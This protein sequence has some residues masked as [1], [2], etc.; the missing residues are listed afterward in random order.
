MKKAIISSGIFLSASLLLGS[1]SKFE[2]INTN[3][4]DATADQVQVEYF[5]NNSI[6]KAQMDPHIAERVF[7]LYWK[8]AAHQHV[9]TG[10]AG[11]TTDDGW[12]TDYFRYMSEWLN[13]ANSAIS[14]ADEHLAAAAPIRKE[15]TANLKE[16]ARIWRAYLMSEWT[17]N[18]GPVPINAFQG[19]NPEYVDVKQVYYFLLA[20]LKDA[21]AKLD[22]NVT[23][24]P[25]TVSNLDPAYGYNAAKWR[26]YANSMRMRLAM[27][28]SEVD[29]EKARAEFEDAV[30]GEMISSTDY[31]FQVQEKDGWSPLSGVMSREWNPQL[32]P[33]SLENIYVG[34]GGVPSADLVSADV[35]SHIKPAN[36]AGLRIT[37]HLSTITNEPYAG[38]WM[39]GLPNTIDPRAYKAFPLPGDISNPS[40]PAWPTGDV[41]TWGTTQRNLM[42]PNETVVKTLDGA[43]TFNGSHAGDWG[44]KGSLNQVRTWSGSNP[45][46]ALEFRKSTNKRIFFAPWETYFLIAEAAVRGWTVPMTGQEAYEEGIR[47]SL[48]YWNVSQFAS[49][50]LASTSYNRLGTSVKWDH[51]T[52][53]PASYSMNYVDGYTNTPGS[54]NI[55]YPVNNLYQNGNVKN[56]QLSKII[57]QKYIAQVPWL[58]LEAWSDKRRLGLPFLE[59]PA[60]EGELQN[61]KQLTAG[62]YMT[63]RVDFFPQRLIYPTSLKNTNAKGY[64]Q[65]VT[66]LGGT[67]NVFTPLWWAKK[68]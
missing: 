65:A 60:R 31:T 22:V 44:T 17:D 56:D 64:T 20:E 8:T 58:P 18:F 57:T 21:A 15:Y 6:I 32:M 24:I 5:L 9:G 29:A 67:D 39:D 40:F 49:T 42:G 62:N 63:S 2:E 35:Q 68:N 13:H 12:S 30:K 34:L 23:N 47:S 43:Y 11:G 28:L 37:N 61:M 1:C 25:A 59:N 38:F 45:R 3:P 27:R 4:K 14:V 48:A 53:P 46:L 54:V 19:Q 52:E 51:T 26:R 10:I 66:A 55:L 36:Y 33:T 7:V 41:A 50:Y 16:I